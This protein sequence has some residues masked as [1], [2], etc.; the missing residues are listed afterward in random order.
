MIRA[1]TAGS[2]IEL[3][4][5]ACAVVLAMIGLSGYRTFAMA[6]T[7]TI[8][9]GLGLLADGGVIAARWADATT[10]LGSNRSEVGRGAGAEMFAGIVG[11]VLGILALV[12]VLSFA[13]LP[14]AA[15]ILGA[16]V[17]FGD[18]T[19]PEP[20]GLVPRRDRSSERVARDDRRGSSNTLIIA[21][22][23]AVVLGIL[24]LI[25]VG[26]TA[27]LILVAML[28]IGAALLTL[29]SRASRESRASFHT[30]SEG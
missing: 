19:E 25:H 14:I 17:V 21:G 6:A 16:S 3:L 5:G 18:A 24:G 29:I 30:S 22:L 13:L 20:V 9:I 7:A 28:A 15:I 27:T 12:H 11:I 4:A 2:S 1:A 8:A 23:G 10:G 26:P